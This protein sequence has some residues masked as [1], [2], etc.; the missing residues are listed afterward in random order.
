MGRWQ[1]SSGDPSAV[2]HKLEHAQLLRSKPAMQSGH[3]A[4]FK[5]Q[6]LYQQQQQQQGGGQQ[7]TSMGIPASP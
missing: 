4:S 6:V 3:A 5:L 1:G 7:A 2:L